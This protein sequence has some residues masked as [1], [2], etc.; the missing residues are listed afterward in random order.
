MQTAPRITVLQAVTCKAGCIHSSAAAPPANS[1]TATKN[2][3]K[4]L[5]LTSF[6]KVFR[7]LM[8]F[9]DNEPAAATSMTINDKVFSTISHSKAAKIGTIQAFLSFPLRWL[10]QLSHST[11][12]ARR[13]RCIFDQRRRSPRVRG[14]SGAVSL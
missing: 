1:K 3:L 9:S 10:N 14:K 13:F 8:T 11:Q 4:A 2:L 5:Y 6:Q 7:Y 12:Q